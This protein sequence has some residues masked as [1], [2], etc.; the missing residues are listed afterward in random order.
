MEI[1]NLEDRYPTH[2]DTVE[3]KFLEVSR[4]KLSVKYIGKGT[5]AH[6]VGISF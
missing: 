3:T 1:E 5:H 2:L 4:D 6:D